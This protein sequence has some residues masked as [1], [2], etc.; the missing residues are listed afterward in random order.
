MKFVMNEQLKHRL[1]G[2]VVL[3]S[4]GVIFVPAMIKKSTRHLG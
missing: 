1:T 2:L 3:L 4:L